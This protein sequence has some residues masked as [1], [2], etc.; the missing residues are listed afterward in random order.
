MWV[1]VQQDQNAGNPEQTE[2]FVPLQGAN[3]VNTQKVIG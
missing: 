3:R 1:S 2:K